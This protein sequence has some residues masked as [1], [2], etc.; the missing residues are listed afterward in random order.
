[1]AEGQSGRGQTD[2]TR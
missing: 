2:L 1:V